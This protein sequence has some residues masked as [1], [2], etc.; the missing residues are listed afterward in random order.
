M[1]LLCLAA[2]INV[3]FVASALAHKV[4]VFAYVEGDRVMVE[5]YFS[6]NVKAQNC[7]VLVFDSAGNKLIEGKTDTKGAYS[8]GLRDLPPF[9]GGLKIVL[10]AEM[11]HRA[12]FNL[13]ESEIPTRRNHGSQKPQADDTVARAKKKPSPPPVT[14]K[15]AEPKM[16]APPQSALD[17]EAL[18][19][20]LSAMLDQK[21]APIV[22]MLGNQ[23]RILLESRTAG[24]SLSEI[25]GGIGW[26]LG[27]VG[28][29]AFF[30]GKKR[31]S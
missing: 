22:K 24:P 4:N 18:Q 13:A 15:E 28:T 17:E 2:V 9:K 20:S 16:A 27:I 10:E 1:R 14:D 31:A 19:K 30:W 29:A 3:A 21:L 8:F 7:Q 5:G 25:V 12:E 26:I 23:E 11:G 6:G